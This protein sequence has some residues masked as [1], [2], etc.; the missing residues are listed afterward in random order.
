LKKAATQTTPARRVVKLKPG[1]KP[2]KSFKSRALISSNV[3][4]VSAVTLL[5]T[6]WMDSER[7]V[8]VTM[9]SASSVLD[10]LVTGATACAATQDEQ[11]AAAVPVSAPA[12]MR[13][14]LIH[15]PI[16]RRHKQEPSISA[17]FF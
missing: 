7:R 12:I 11:S 1:T 5:G 15:P 2:A 9:T 10:P 13:N 6:F 14:E 4:E 17:L 8:A 3:P 16:F